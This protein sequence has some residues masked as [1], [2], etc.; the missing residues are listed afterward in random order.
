MNTK[1]IFLFV[2]L[3]SMAFVSCKKCADCAC[4]NTIVYTYGDDVEEDT[5]TQIENGVTPTLNTQFP[6]S[7]N[8]IC[9]RGGN[10]DDD[11]DEYEDESE[12]ISFTNEGSTEY[13]YT[14]K[15]TCICTDQ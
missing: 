2:A 13:S 5:K 11:K 4:N 3:F 15:R 6:E 14:F 8:E 12:T 9:A 7:T 1:H 10:F